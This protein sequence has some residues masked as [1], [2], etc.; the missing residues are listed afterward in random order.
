MPEIT[1]PQIRLAIFLTLFAV[2]AGLEFFAPRRELR[3]ARSRR[4]LTNW[5]IAII[6]SALVRL[7]FVGA[8]VGAATWATSA[9]I[10]LFNLVRLPNWFELLVSFIVLD[11]AIWLSHVASHKIPI[12]WVVHRMHHSDIDIDVSTAIRFH[13]IEIILSMVWKIV[14]VVSL[15]APAVAVLIFEIVLNGAAM[16][17]HS[18]VR[19][20]L[21][22]DRI[23]R[24]IIVTPDMHR[25]HHSVINRET[26][27]NYGFNLAIWDRVFG[28]YV[29]QPEKGHAKMKIG[30]S[31]WQDERPVRLVWT[32]AI[33]FLTTE[34]KI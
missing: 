5:I 2:L 15:G 8:A 17:N 29:D 30:L 21:F 6:D 11:F 14:V 28:T 12:L 33:P 1:E 31:D 27:S 7:L 16:F 24:W 3:V 32:L 25:V 22:L 34:K 19:L 26:D 20:P 9:N 10:G 18:N 23:L 13:P 4:W